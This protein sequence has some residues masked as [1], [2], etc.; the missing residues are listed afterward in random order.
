M[1][2]VKTPENLSDLFNEFNN[3]SDQNKNQKNVS[4]S[5]YCDLNEIKPFNKLSPPDDF[6]I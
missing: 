3:F 4:N 5:K 2:C 6:F 1:S